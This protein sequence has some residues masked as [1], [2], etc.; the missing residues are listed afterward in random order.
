MKISGWT[1]VPHDCEQAAEVKKII[2][3]SIDYSA[4]RISLNESEIPVISKAGLQLVHIWLVSCGIK[5]IC[6]CLS[7]EL[8][9]Q[10]IKALT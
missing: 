2:V 1:H 9:V 7:D 4:L 8:R 6:R 3:K 10:E 5:L